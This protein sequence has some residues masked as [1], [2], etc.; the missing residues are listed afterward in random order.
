MNFLEILEVNCMDDD[1]TNLDSNVFLVV[2]AED[3]VHIR[4]RVVVNE[5]SSVWIKRVDLV[6]VQSDVMDRAIDR[7]HLEVVRMEIVVF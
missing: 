7:R 5:P 3:R 6:F 2:L 4:Q 1:S